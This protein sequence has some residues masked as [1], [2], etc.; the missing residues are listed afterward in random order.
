MIFDCKM[1]HQRSYGGGGG[2][3]FTTMTLTKM[4]LT[5]KPFDLGC[6]ENCRLHTVQHLHDQIFSQQKREQLK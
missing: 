2:G 4:T 1:T 5:F 3:N 6:G